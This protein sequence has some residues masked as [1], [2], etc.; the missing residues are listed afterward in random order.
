MTDGDI[1]DY[2]MYFGRSLDLPADGLE[3]HVKVCI[4]EG[5]RSLW[6]ARAWTWVQQDYELTVSSS[7]ETTNLPSWFDGFITVREKGS[8]DGK[9]LLYY[10]KEE[11]DRLLPKPGAYSSNYPEVYTVY[12]DH[13][14]KVWKFSC[15][16]YS[17]TTPLYCKM[18]RKFTGSVA[19]IPDRAVDALYACVAHKMFPLGTLQRLNAQQEKFNE[20]KLL[21]ESDSPY[22]GHIVKIL[23]DTAEHIKTGWVWV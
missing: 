1:K 22:R 7:D 10:P 2:F 4:R 20:I 8:Q 18:V 11:Y 13:A 3:N 21:E 19:D 6:Y 5:I 9:E 17:T 16:P 12:Y 23:D 14:D 15:F